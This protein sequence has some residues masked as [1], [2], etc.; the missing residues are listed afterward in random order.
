ME[1]E[2]E[3]IAPLVAQ[4]TVRQ[5]QVH[6]TFTCPK[7]GRSVESS[8]SL[9]KD[10]SAGQRMKDSVKRSFMHAA[11][12]MLTRALGSLFG[13]GMAGQ[14]ARSATYEAQRG[15]EARLAFSKADVQRGIV[16]AFER[17][18]AQFAKDP[19][20][21]A[22]VAS[23]AVA[24]S[25][26]AYDQLLA[27]HPISEGW[28]R[29]ILARVLVEVARADGT[30]EPRE[31]ALLDQLL[32]GQDVRQ[33]AAKPALSAAELGGTSAQ[34]RPSILLLA[35]SLALADEELS[36]EELTR[37]DAIGTGLGFG[38]DKVAELR[39][40]AAQQVIERVLGQVWRSGS[41]DAAA[42]A[43]LEA[44]ATACGVS[45]GELAQQEVAFRKRHGFF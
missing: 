17:V 20:S 21:G 29:A 3:D 35:C 15:V 30:L 37:L 28:D 11:R 23:G 25:Q 24:A 4:Q 44:L 40:L 16:A 19:E 6:V 31:L 14:V 27:A 7:S 2:Y 42:R 10:N 43:E 34:A 39:R 45:A 32:P 13:H 9:R 33:L 8:A 12:N 22:W 18:R 1:V 41:C 26:S 5:R 36:A 38:R